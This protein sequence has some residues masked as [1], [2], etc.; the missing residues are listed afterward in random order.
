MA[1]IT[2]QSIQ[3]SLLVVRTQAMH[4]IICHCRE[5]GPRDGRLRPTL[6]QMQ[7]RDLAEVC[8]MLQQHWQENH[9]ELMIEPVMFHSMSRA[10]LLTWLRGS[11]YDVQQYPVE[12]RV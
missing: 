1:S 11:G 8:L 3:T 7:H 12:E 2:G 4:R 6:C 9:P 5:R 10:K